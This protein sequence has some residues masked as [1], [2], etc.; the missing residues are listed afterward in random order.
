MIHAVLVVLTVAWLVFVLARRV[1]SGRHWL[2]LLPDLL[3]PASYLAVP[4][5]LVAVAIG[6]QAQPWCAAGGLAALVVG[7]G[8]SGL[9]PSALRRPAP[10]PPNAIRVV[11]W[12]T[13]Y[14]DQAETAKRLHEFLAAQRADI[15]LLQER[16]HG[17]HVEP[18]QVHDLPRLRAEFP[19]YHI[20][21]AGELI[22]LSR[23]PLVP[24]VPVEDRCWRDVFDTTKFL[25]TDVRVGTVVL[26]LYNVHIPTQYVLGDNPFRRSFYTGLRDRHVHR[27]AHLRHLRADLA[28]NPHASVVSGDFNST[29]AMGE[30]R[31]LLRHLRS[32]NRAARELWPASWPAGGLPLWQLD[33]TFTSGV[34]VHRYRFLDPRGI[35][36]H[37]VQ[38]L[39]VSLEGKTHG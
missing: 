18:R 16:I 5:M 12:N 25:R 22:T 17:R 32:A 28:A 13:E 34:R 27:T 26:S 33:W 3:P 2:W 37:R 23:F 36:D 20:A 19:R 11:S 39:L 15:Y 21:A 7:I 31:W 38:E 4:A 9:N 35:S 10:A 8:H 29:S 24:G 1:F 14:W 30:L 6:M